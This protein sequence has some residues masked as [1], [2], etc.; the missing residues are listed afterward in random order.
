MEFAECEEI[1]RERG[2]EREG[3]KE[4][5]RGRENEREGDNGRRDTW[6]GLRPRVKLAH[7]LHTIY[8]RPVTSPSDC[9]Q[10]CTNGVVGI[11]DLLSYF[12][13]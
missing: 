11:R 5:D 7:G 8:S 2:G 12:R 9:L 6:P 10:C 1:Q 3:E 13:A 4:K